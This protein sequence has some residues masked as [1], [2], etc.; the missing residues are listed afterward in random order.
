MK[1]LAPGHQVTRQSEVSPFIKNKEE[2]VWVKEKDRQM[3]DRQI[4][5]IDR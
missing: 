2:K 4:D 5:D 1:M 3:I